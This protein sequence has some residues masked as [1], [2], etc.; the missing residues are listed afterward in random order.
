MRLEDILG[1]AKQNIKLE[2]DEIKFLL[3]QT[4][5]DKLD[6]IFET[7]REVREQHFGNKLF[8]Y[9]FVYFSTYCKN[10]C[11]FCYYRAKNNKPPRYRKELK[12]IIDIAVQ[13]KESGVHM[14]DLTMGEDPYYEQH[15]EELVKIVSEVKKATD[16]PI[17]VSPGVVPDS[18]IASLYHAGAD[19]FALY[20]ETHNRELYK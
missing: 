17:M 11:S 9:G 18:V 19:W 7:A 10:N 13:L 14:I 20:Q 5:K 3:C 1:K 8:A 6:K 16:L 4:E 2:K 12:E 15:P